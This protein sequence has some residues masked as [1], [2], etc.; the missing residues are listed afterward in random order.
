MIV[1]STLPPK[2]R[3]AAMRTLDQN[4]AVRLV[5]EVGLDKEEAPVAMA[6]R[7]VR[8]QRQPVI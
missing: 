4:F 6:F 3:I 1:P 7:A 5:F 2:E 8:E